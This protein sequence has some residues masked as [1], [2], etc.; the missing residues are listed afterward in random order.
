MADTDGTWQLV[1][2][3]PMG[4]S[5]ARL[6]LK[7]D[8]TGLSGTWRS[9]L[10]AAEFTGG[11][12]DGDHLKISLVLPVTG[13]VSLLATIK[14]DKLTGEVEGPRGKFPVTGTRVR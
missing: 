8:A 9:Q 12:V 1:L 3:T 11:E 6:I 13:Q 7:T 10:A 4:R 2:D 5:A 14:G